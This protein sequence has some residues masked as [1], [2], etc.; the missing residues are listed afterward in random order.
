MSIRSVD[1]MILYSKTSDIEKFQ[2]VE[3]QQARVSQD[4][5]GTQETRRKEIEEK[6]APETNKDEES[7]KIHVQPDRKRK[8]GSKEDNRGEPEEETEAAGEPDKKFSASPH[9]GA[10]DITI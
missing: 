9:S 6:K 3:Q 7:G 2:Q 5:L 10:I 1:L 4:Q 8:E